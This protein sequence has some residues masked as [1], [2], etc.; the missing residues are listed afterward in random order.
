[1]EGNREK[2]S[3]ADLAIDRAQAL[4]SWLTRR[5]GLSEPAVITKVTT[6]RV[7]YSAETLLLDVQYTDAGKTRE[8]PLVARI[9]PSGPGMFPDVDFKFHFQV[10]DLAFK[11]GLTVPRVLWYA[12][13]AEGPFGE[14]FLVM[15]RVEGSVPPEN[16]PYGAKG[17]VLEASAADQRRIFNG[18]IEHLARLHTLDWTELDLEFIPTVAAGE[19]G[20]AAEM[21]NLQSYASWVLDGRADPVIAK[22]FDVLGGAMPTC[23]RLCLNWGDPKLSNIIY[24]DNEPV[25]LLDWELATVAPPEN[26]LMFFLV[27]H[28]LITRAAGYPDL[29]G[30]PGESE[31]IAFYKR[32]TGFSLRHLEWFR[33]WHMLRLDLMSLRFTQLLLLTGKIS[34]TS[35][36]TPHVTPRRLL[37]EALFVQPG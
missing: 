20:M 23:D 22:A 8:L 31:A 16:P 4:L 3:K 10:L 9:R 24:R 1:M 30:F 11:A 33:L 32:L 17:W 37:R 21:R 12:D 13:A 7:G 18:A 25:A 19:P 36:I 29:P 28:H 35:K 2:P 26:D 34:A 6:P 27:Y 5:L 14:P 15:E